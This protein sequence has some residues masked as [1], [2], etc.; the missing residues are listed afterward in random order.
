M[1]PVKYLWAVR[2]LMAK[3]SFKHF[4]NMS[5]IGKPLYIEGKRKISVG[6]RTRIFP[7]I[8]MEAIKNGSIVIGSNTVMEQN[9]HII[10]MDSELTI[11][12]DVTIA[13][14][15]FITNVNH[16][17]KDIE[18]SVMNQGHIVK[19]TVIGDGCFI[20]YGAAIQAGTILGKHCIVGTNA[21]VR[22]TF[23]DYSVIV[24]VPARVIKQY[25]EKTKTWKKVTQ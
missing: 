22:G 19:E 13:P 3:L 17:Y 4:G 20:G 8:R 2:G 23:P 6:N 25:D 21:V 7:G 16:D 5:Y 14:N 12:N 24:G 9:V 15:V 10:S 18:K 11:G 1:H